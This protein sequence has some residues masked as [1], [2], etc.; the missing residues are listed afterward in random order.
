MA[1]E[2]ET[3][4]RELEDREAIKELRHMYCYYV[5]QG[6]YAEC[7]G[8]FAEDAVADFSPLGV[9]RGINEVRKFYCETIPSLF[10]SM[11]HFVHNHT[12]TLDGD[13]GQGSCYFE[14]K[15]ISAKGEGFVGAGHYDDDLVR[16]NGRWKFKGR[17]V[18]FYFFMPERESWTQKD[19][20]KLD[21]S[22]FR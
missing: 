3:R 22:Q 13:R 12:L 20:L 15:G 21:V 7:A 10:T 8:L 18:T 1:K 5:D 11:L 9:F 2:L 19:R 16:V 6:R 17:K 14:F 4:L